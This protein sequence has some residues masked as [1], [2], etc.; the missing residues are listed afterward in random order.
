MDSGPCPALYTT[1]DAE[2]SIQQCRDGVTNLKY[3]PTNNVVAVTLRTKGEARAPAGPLAN[4]TGAAMN[5][6]ATAALG[7]L[8]DS[9]PSPEIPHSLSPP[10][11]AG[12]YNEASGLWDSEE[13][14]NGAQWWNSANSLEVLSSLPFRMVLSNT[15]VR[16]AC[17]L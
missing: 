4:H 10:W 15:P 6:D 16:P 14:P 8:Q 11:Q 5:S 9:R 2:E 7:A 3:C 13:S 1:V 12:W 17:P